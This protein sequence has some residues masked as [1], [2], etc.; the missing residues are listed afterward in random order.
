[1]ITQ[2]E[3]KTHVHYNPE[4]GVFTRL[5]GNFKGRVIKNKPDLDGHIRIKVKHIN[6]FS[7][8]L[9]W[10]YMT[11]SFPKECIDHIDRNPANNVFSN[12]REATFKEN[13]RNSKMFC[14]NTSGVKGVYW[15]KGKKR[16]YAHCRVN[17]KRHF[18]GLFKDIGEAE[19]AVNAFRELHHGEFASHGK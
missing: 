1:M 4:T 12:L 19:K 10:L 17:S 11:G 15:H 13:S 7:H 2:E 14:T 16:W 18:V 3:L 9:A 5:T 6:Y 8:R